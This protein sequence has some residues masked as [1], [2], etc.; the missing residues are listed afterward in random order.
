MRGSIDSKRQP[1]QMLQR[2][3]DRSVNSDAELLETLESRLADGYT[4]IEAARQLGQDVTAWEAFWIQLLH[5]YE[6][7]VD[8]FPEA[9]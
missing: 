7:A 8:D 2:S 5:Q 9:A 3:E 6:A 1:I 4:R